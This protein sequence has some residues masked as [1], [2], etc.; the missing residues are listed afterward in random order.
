MFR[1]PISGFRAYLTALAGVVV[2]TTTRSALQPLLNADYPYAIYYFTLLLTIWICGLGPSIM[3]LV[4]GSLA[5]IYFFLP[6][7]AWAGLQEWSHMLA[8]LFYL[9]LGGTGI[10]ITESQRRARR[11]AEEATSLLNALLSSSPIGLGY[12]G[13]DCRYRAINEALAELGGHSVAEHLGKT[14]AEVSPAMGHDLA[15]IHRRVL[16]TGE[17]ELGR[18]IVIESGDEISGPR[19]LQTHTFPVRIAGRG[20]VGIGL[21]VVDLTERIRLMKDLR[22]S[23]ERIR[24]IYDQAAVGIV[25]FRHD[26]SLT[27]AN[28]GFCRMTGRE[29]GEIGGMSLADLLPTPEPGWAGLFDADEARLPRKDGTSLWVS[30]T[31]NTLRD[32]DG[33]PQGGLAIV[34][35]VSQR[36]AAEEALRESHRQFRD[37]ADAIPQLVFMTDADGRIGYVNRGWIDYTGLNLEQCRNVTGL[38]AIAHSDDLHGMLERWALSRRE[39]VEFDYQLRLRRAVDG[40]YRWFLSR[41]VPVLDDRGRIVQWFGTATDIE[42][43]KRAEESLLI[44]NAK[45]RRLVDSN[46]IGVLFADRDRITDANDAVLALTGRDRDDLESGR[47]DWRELT[48]P[49]YR[50]AA[51]KA[52]AEMLDRGVCTPFPMEFS[53]PDGSRVPILI[54]G[55]LIDAAVPTWVCFVQDMTRIKQVEHELREG[56]RRKDEFLAMLAHELRNPLAPIRNGVEILEMA[57]SDD[58]ESRR[59]ACSVIDRQA[60]HLTS[61]VDDLLDVSRITRGKITLNMVPLD[62]ATVVQAALESSRPLIQAKNHTLEID[63]EPRPVRISGDA[64]RLAQVVTNLLNNAVKYTPEGGRIRLS[65]GRVN[66]D[67]VIRVADNGEGLAP[68]LIPR[69]FDLFEQASR[70]IDRSEGGLGIGLTLAKRLVEMHHGTIEV[71]SA[72]P[73]LGSEFLV[74]LPLIADDVDGDDDDVPN[75]AVAADVGGRPRRIL[76][77]DDNVD[78]ARTLAC[79]LDQL[80]HT[81]TI[82]HDGPSAIDAAA[83]CLPDLALLDIGLPGMD[84]FEVARRLRDGPE[85]AGIQIIAL[86][87][88]GSE[89]D[90]RRSREAGFDHHLIKPLE[91]GVLRRILAEE[92]ADD[93]TDSPVR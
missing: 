32:G 31:A 86:T 73:D 17:P 37:L 72:G 74:R 23:E 88:Y 6:P 91:F 20:V 15:P 55:A 53:R 16:Q 51:E 87:G 80:G 8:M 12:L 76:L 14:V 85:H 5:G 61:L 84:G 46:I 42:D 25:T 47:L 63:D 77:V 30:M 44:Q 52:R 21:A 22:A 93:P 29:P 58:D 28:P 18:E 34:L 41:A 9:S 13:R 68:E 35:D 59:W 69:I 78:S 64:T 70:S 82:A 39:G 54:G 62:V 45:I 65:I 26:G 75:G 10:L 81:V 24:R 50:A 57:E 36:R 66:S 67:A 4:L 3:A 2:A 33:Q 49:E 40:Q 43:Q 83:A 1:L 60:R 90:R 38:A 71:Q 11:R 89:A 27:F 48:P 79:L 56:D 19:T 92:R 7:F